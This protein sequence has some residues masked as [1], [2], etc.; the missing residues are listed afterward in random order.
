MGGMVFCGGVLCGMGWYTMAYPV[1][2]CSVMFYELGGVVWYFG[3]ALYYIMRYNT[4]LWCVIVHCRRC[5][6]IVCL[7][8]YFVMWNDMLYCMYCMVCMVHCSVL[9]NSIFWY[10]T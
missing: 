3:M 7:I 1:M 6:L 8:V 10:D 9:W 5:Y 2:F 4:C